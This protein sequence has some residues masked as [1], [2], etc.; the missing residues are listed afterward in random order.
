MGTVNKAPQLI[1]R[2]FE[3]LTTVGHARCLKNHLND[4]FVKINTSTGEVSLYGDGDE[5]LNAIEIYG[6]IKEDALRPTPEM[7]DTLYSVIAKL[8]SRA[9][10]DSP[11]FERPF[12][13]ELVTPEFETLEHLLFLDDDTIKLSAPLL[14]GM[15]EDLDK[16]ISDLLGDLN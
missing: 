3:D 8:D 2:L 5:L 14:E 16:F 10:W 6:W 9:Y 11:Y 7:I 4:L 12:S 1:E 13:I 15:S